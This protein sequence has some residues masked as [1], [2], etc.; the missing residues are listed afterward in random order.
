[1]SSF[2]FC[3]LTAFLLSGIGIS[4]VWGDNGHET[5]TAIG[6]SKPLAFVGAEGFGAFARGG[7]G[8]SE[9]AVTTTDDTGREGSLRWALSQSGPRIVIFKVGGIFSLKKNLPV[10]EPFLTLDGSSAPD[11][12]VTLKDGALDIFDTHDVV[13]RYLRVRPGDEAALGKNAWRDHPRPIKASDAVTIKDS[14]D[15][16]IDHVSASWSTD[17]TVSVTRSRRVTVQNCIIAEPLANP[18]LHV[19]DGVEI[20]HP[21]G[22]L[23]EGDEVSYLKNYFAYFRIRGP[24]LAASHE[25]HRVRTAAINNL[26]AFYESS[27]TRIKASHTAADFI[28]QNNVYTHPLKSQAPEVHILLERLKN[29]GLRHPEAD[30]T[31]GQTHIFLQGNLGPKRQKSHEDEWAGIQIDF[32]SDVA[33]QLRIDKPPFELT[34]FVLLPSTEVEKFVL[35]NAGAIL[36]TRD[37]ID[38]RLIRQY[39]ANA[40]K[41]IS[42]QDDVGGYALP[43]KKP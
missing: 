6:S 33:K 25:G 10:K 2:R 38:E 27:G 9:I 23:V 20:S 40:G 1:M 7:T 3:C 29:E 39:H 43:K 17:E 42:S 41:I 12:G 16:I 36:P 31:I 15:V 26:V 35:A 19:E 4:S 8:G 30:A 22:A 14:S 18:K 32:D 28:V 34:P 24:Q 21:F 37:P 5:G 13:V 11:G